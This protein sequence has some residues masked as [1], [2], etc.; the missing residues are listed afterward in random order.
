VWQ[1][2]GVGWVKRKARGREAFVIWR[3]VLEKVKK[4]KTNNSNWNLVI[5]DS[6]TLVVHKV[7]I[8]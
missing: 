6:L 1:T 3:Q 4:K 2:R 8:L 7:S 5:G